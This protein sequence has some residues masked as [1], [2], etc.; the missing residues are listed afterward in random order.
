VERQPAS[1]RFDRPIR[2]ADL[3]RLS[4]EDLVARLGGVFEN[5]P[6]VAQVIAPKGPFTSVEQLHRAMTEGVRHASEQQRINLL[7]AHPEL[8]GKAARAGQM[9]A[10]STREQ[11]RAALDDLSRADYA[12]FDRLN[13]KY[14]EKFG[15]PFIIAVREHTRESI[16]AAFE[17]RIAHSREQEL[18]AA[19]QQ[20]FT[21]A[22][23]RLEEL[24]A[25]T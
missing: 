22:R 25:Q 10:A 5:S 8:A 4:A 17:Q 12:R 23:Y 3:P 18:E 13:K 24:I 11:S 1:G 19:L 20:V 16:F 2:I 9:T 6:W 7:T 15:F 21:I 14:R